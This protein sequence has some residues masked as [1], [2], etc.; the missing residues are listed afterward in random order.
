MYIKPF[1]GIP[2]D[3]TDDPTYSDLLARANAVCST[4][5]MLRAEGVEFPE[6]YDSDAVITADTVVKAY[7]NDPI[8]TSRKADLSAL[9]TGAL[10][11]T[12]AIMQE[13]GTMVLS[14]AAEIRNLVTNKLIIESENADPKVR[15]KAIELLGKMTDVGLFTERKHVTVT[16][17]T[18]E[19]LAAKL[20]EKLD[21]LHTLVPDSTG[22]YAVQP[23]TADF[24]PLDVDDATTELQL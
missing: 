4:E 23:M 10:R 3:E 16:H 13:F 20:R 17:Y 15:L 9:S 14:S 21:K 8:S 5:A 12:S 18:P 7:A 19:E 2:I 24:E 6:Y 1:A 11:L 22:T